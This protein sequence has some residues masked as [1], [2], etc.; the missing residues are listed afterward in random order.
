MPRGKGS[1]PKSPFADLDTD[2]KT[3][4]EGAKDEEI[5]AKISEV[6]LNESDN[7]E[8]KKKDVQL[9]E[10]KQAAKDAGQQYADAT[11]MNRLRINYAKTI[12]E[13]RGK[14]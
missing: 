1:A 8:N 13:A 3:L 2:Y 5:R 7:L 11:K 4:I 9:E 14:R 12:L 6:A 10:A